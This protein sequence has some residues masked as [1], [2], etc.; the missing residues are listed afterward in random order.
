M[1]GL[2]RSYHILPLSQ[3]YTFGNL[4]EYVLT[5]HINVLKQWHLL[6]DWNWNSYGDSLL[7]IPSSTV[8]YSMFKGHAVVILFSRSDERKEKRWDACKILR[9]AYIQ[10]LNCIG[11]LNEWGNLLIT[12]LLILQYFMKQ[13]INTHDAYFVSDQHLK[14]VRSLI[15]Y[16]RI[17]HVIPNYQKVSSCK[18][19][20]NLMKCGSRLIKRN[21]N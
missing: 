2:V 6:S 20:L 21:R 17:T 15:Y 7:A 14:S 4:W 1:T 11:Q 5:K 13:T 12:V 16:S 10:L 8:H 18:K 3:H 19:Q 9:L